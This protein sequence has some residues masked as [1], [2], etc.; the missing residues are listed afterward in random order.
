MPAVALVGSTVGLYFQIAELNQR[1]LLGERSIAYASKTLD[2]VKALALAGA[3]TKLEIA[4]SEQNLESQ[5]ASQTEWVELRVEVRN[6]LTV[7][8]D[9]HPWPEASE[10]ARVPTA[11]PP[12]GRC[13]VCPPRS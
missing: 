7:V 4:E 6:A 11:P 3:A 13:G 8:L 2:L 12:G 9:G 5:R 10:L 1:V